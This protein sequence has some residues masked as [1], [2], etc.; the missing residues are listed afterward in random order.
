MRARRE[1]EAGREDGL[2]RLLDHAP[3]ALAA[4][5]LLYDRRARQGQFP[6]AEAVL[7]RI[8]R[9][10]PGNPLPALALASLLVRRDALAAAEPFA[11]NA[12]RLAPTHPMAHALMGLILTEGHQPLAGEHHYRRA[13]ALTE[14]PSAQLLANLAWNLKAQG[15]VAEARALYEQAAALGP[16]A[17]N[18]LYG[19]ARLEEADRQF[20][21]SAQL[22]DQAEALAPGHPRLALQRAVLHRRQDEDAAALALLDGLDRPLQAAGSQ[23]DVGLLLDVL[24]ERGVL[25]DKMGRHA[26]S[27]D[28]FARSKAAMR[29]FTGQAYKAAEAEALAQ[30]LKGFF[31]AE[32]VALLPRAGVR[33]D[34]AQPVFIVGFPRSGTTLVEQTLSAHPRISAGDELPVI[35]ELTGLV[36]QLLASPMPYPEGLADL[37]FGDRS[38]GLDTLRDH[39]LQRAR[40]F[41]AIGEGADWFTDKMPLNETHLG[42]ITLVFPKAPVIH[43]IRHPLDVALSV[44]ANHMSH[45]FDC[46]AELGA[47]VRHYLLI[48][49]LMEHYRANLP[50]NYLAVRYEDLV[51]DQ[52]TWVRRMLAFIG[53]D[54][55][56]RCLDFHENR[57][58][59]RTASY[60]Q[61]AEKL[62][63]RSRYRYRA[64]LK[65][66]APVIPALE[67]VIRRLGYTVE[68]GG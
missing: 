67:P 29:R 11:R 61:V 35:G 12:V 15:R 16:A 40:Q 22:L 52:E 3:T 28:A 30:R 19:W 6:A 42:L 27:F 13:L 31:T 57:R 58:Y 47:I 33:P 36:P 66:L 26:D 63:G 10:D 17:F 7:S 4:L 25:L 38:F 64:Y 14:A 48:A 1:L 45:G 53:A 43:L 5:N 2:R 9:L 21:R 55:D 20:V 60:A 32:R 50:L 68:N 37:W 62:H 46:A 41:G 44:F 49:D 24:A 56:P 39:Y 18:T 51:D 65:E 59:A 54:Y 8:V 23:V 34:I